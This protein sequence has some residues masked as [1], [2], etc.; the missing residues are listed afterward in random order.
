MLSLLEGQD[1]VGVEKYFL[2]R[3]YLVEVND[4]PGDA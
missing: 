3:K 1:D 2:K 4:V